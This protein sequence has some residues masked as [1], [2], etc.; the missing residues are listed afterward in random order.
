MENSM[1]DILSADEHVIMEERFLPDIGLFWLKAKYKLTNKRIIRSAPHVILGLIPSGRTERSLPLHNIV[2]V[3]TS[4]EFDFWRFA[5]GCCLIIIGLVTARYL[6]GLPIGFVG[7]ILTLRP[8][9]TSFAFINNAG[10]PTTDPISNWE[11]D[12]VQNFAAEVNKVIVDL[13]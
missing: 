11:W 2:S 10:Q 5:L 13:K 1:Y 8:Y 3:M 12:K 9:H 7:L 6:I 4:H